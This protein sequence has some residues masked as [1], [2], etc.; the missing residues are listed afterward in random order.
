[1][2][3]S[4]SDH[5]LI[6]WLESSSF[7]FND[8][9]SE[10]RISISMKQKKKRTIQIICIKFY[11]SLLRSSPYW[12][13]RKTDNIKGQSASIWRHHSVFNRTLFDCLWCQVNK[14]CIMKT[15]RADKGCDG[16]ISFTIA[17][18][19]QTRLHHAHLHKHSR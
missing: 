15:S 5:Q 12:N 16:M 18:N 17:N 10:R 8:E 1:M 6:W 3:Y 2:S 11:T 7:L 19:S 4:D 9:S 14:H 13:Y